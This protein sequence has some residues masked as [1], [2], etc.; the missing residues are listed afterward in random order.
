MKKELSSFDIRAI[1]T[2]LSA[3]EGAHMDKIHH[4]GS[5]V[6][7]R[8]N[9]PGQGKTELLFENRKWLYC[10]SRKPETP[11]MPTTFASFLRKYID[12]ARIGKVRQVGFDRI[13][14][15]E[16]TK[17]DGE[18]RLVLEMF[19][20]GNVLLLKDGVILNCLVQKTYR[21]R[22]TRPNE[23]YVMPKARF[24][25]TSSSEADFLAS[26]R[27]S[28]ADAVR[29]LATAVNLGGQ[30]AEEVCT[31]VGIDKS[32]PA[33]AVDDATVSRMYTAL[34]DIVGTVLNSPEPTAYLK[35][36]RIDD[37]APV[38]LQ[39]RTGLE[40]KRFSTMSEVI[41]T[42]LEENNEAEEDA[43]VD[44]AVE[45][46]EKRIAKQEETVLEYRLQE[47]ESRRRAEALYADYQKADALLKVLDE[48]SAKLTWDRLKEGAAKIPYV[49]SLD[50]SKHLVSAEMGGEEMT[51][52]WTKGVDA[53]ASD[54][55]QHGKDIG[56]KAKR[57]QEALDQS[58]AELAKLQKGIDR[59]KALAAEKAQPTKQFWFERYKWFFTTGGKLVMAG[60]DTH[61]NDNIVK[62][63]LKEGDLYAHADV[64]GAPSV[65]IKEGAKAAPEE[66]RQAC[67]FALAQ[68]KAWIAAMSEGG[69]FWVYPD[70]VSKTPNPGEFVPRGA[71][72]VRGKRNYEYH[73][74][75]ELAIGE[76]W[77]EGAR[78]IMCGPVECFSQS[79]KYMVVRP[80]K[81][82]SGRRTNEIAKR[83]DVPEEE[84]SRIVPPGDLEVVREVW[85]K[86]EEDDERWRR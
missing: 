11:V 32:T 62:K 49:K 30:Y 42:F 21:D 40:E 10:P 34:Q 61:S 39:S 65:V 4:W 14:E 47:E 17:S 7:F 31:R 57:A 50:P 80:G 79:E 35:D 78:K 72:I 12:N 52:D 66:L 16:L 56:E 5:S 70:Q 83:F 63:H 18:Y 46:L 1:V 38:A 24:D 68:S 19:G 58:R 36:G 60:R 53:N 28:D 84:V 8:L 51:L 82:K 85:P 41:E 43:Y 64:H 29:T 26:F 45:K 6:L 9:V 22:K 23:P 3:L 13:V 67:Q 76:I 86:P 73:L 69:A 20:G 71:F 33:S 2:E 59:E 48:Q 44:P 27:S 55:Y 81:P 77:Y 37:F 25:P 54:M 15:I 75:M 74:P